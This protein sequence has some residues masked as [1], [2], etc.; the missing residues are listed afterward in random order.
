MST[1]LLQELGFR[2]SRNL[3]SQNAPERLPDKISNSSK[4]LHLPSG[5]SNLPEKFREISSTPRSSP[6]NVTEEGDR[7]GTRHFTRVL[8]QTFCGT[9]EDRRLETHHRPLL[10]Q[11]VGSDIKVSNGNT[12]DS[13]GGGYTRSMDD[14]YR[15]HRCLL[16]CTSRSRFKKI[17]KILLSRQNISVSS[18]LLRAHNITPSL[19]LNNETSGPH[20]SPRRSKI[21]PVSRRLALHRGIQTRSH[22]Q[23]QQGNTTGRISGTEDQS[24]EI[25]TLSFNQDHLSGDYDRFSTLQ[26]IS[27]REKNQQLPADNRRIPERQPSTSL[28]LA[29]TFGSNGLPRKTGSGKQ[30]K[31]QT[32]AIPAKRRMEISNQQISKGCNISSMQ[33][34]NT[35]VDTGRQ[36]PRGDF[37]RTS[38]NRFPPLYR[39]FKRRL[40]CV[41]RSS[42]DVRIV[43]D[44]GITHSYQQSRT[45]S[46]LQRPEG[47]PKLPSELNSCHYVRQHHSGI[48]PEQTGGDGIQIPMSTDHQT[49]R[50]GR[51]E[52]DSPEVKV[53]TRKTQC[54]GRYIKP[55]TSDTENRVVDQSSSV[56]E[57]LQDMGNSNSRPLRHGSEC[58]TTMLLLPS[59]RPT[60]SR[61]GCLPPRLEQDHRLRLSTNSTDQT[62]AQQ[63]Q[64]RSSRAHTYSSSLASTG[65]V[66]GLASTS[67]RHTDST[68]NDPEIAE[69][70]TQECIS[71]KTR[72]TE[73]SRLEI[74]SNNLQ[75]KGFSQQAATTIAGH[76]RASTQKV[77][78]SRWELF[79]DWCHGRK[80]DPLRASIPLVAD[81][82]L[83]LFHKKEFR[84]ST[85]KGYR[86][87]IGRV[88]KYQ[89]TDVTDNEE[90][91]MLI[92]SLDI[93]RPTVVSPVPKWD[94]ALVLRFLTEPPFEP[95]HQASIKDL[96][97]KTL[98]LLGLAS[99]K[100][101]SEIHALTN[102]LSHTKNWTEISIQLDST[103]LAKNQKPGD[104]STAQH[105]IKIPALAPSVEEGLPDRTL[106]PVRALKYYLKRTESY[107]GNCQKLFLSLAPG[108]A[109][110]VSKVTLSNWI[111]DTIRQAHAQ[112]KEEDALLIK[113]STHELRALATSALFKQTHSLTAVMEAACWRS[114]ST[115]SQFYL[116]DLTITNQEFS[117]LGP[118]VAGQQIIGSTN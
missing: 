28:G 65:M 5:I 56:S 73:P 3:S 91:G 59:S 54:D 4:S 22:R 20:T 66:P 52:K 109:K 92:K 27:I 89:G 85:I 33:T 45:R 67:H 63:G 36:T 93:K 80:T 114:H 13:S 11:Q 55:T 21:A 43:D 79:A 69:T 82:I 19:H 49:T 74:I 50:L 1:K 71:S 32:A 99:A 6:R 23:H 16:P 84:M 31:N 60:V 115:F 102:N 35:L 8:Q 88:L 105:F 106:C 39:C 14:I 47:F 7:S 108:P 75:E 24:R 101:I 90:L 58:K 95:L 113:C 9:Q 103:F 112:A 53:H 87:A 104:P 70:T 72:D 34:S 117:S 15:P 96:S 98:F 62:D 116:R 76:H 97:H 25:R 41:R 12:R 77:Y 26:S 48:V 42:Q 40:G 100:R 51:R 107:R 44:R 38:P 78:E 10:P 81:F 111:K 83:Y 18:T 30:K 2:R 86:S 46:C 64:D 94:L 29:S 68:P 17:P 110:E 61:D 57:N 37:P 118:L